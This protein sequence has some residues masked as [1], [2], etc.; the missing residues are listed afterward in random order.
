MNIQSQKPG[1]QRKHFYQMPLHQTSK[2]LSARLDKGLRK[3]LGKKT[4]PLRKGDDV[5]IMRGKNKKKKGKILRIDR[6]G[7]TVFIEGIIRKKSDGT[8]IP[9]GISSSNLLIIE[10]NRDDQKRVKGKKIAKEKPKTEKK[11]KVKK[12]G[13]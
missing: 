10:I 8:E 6:S 11:K 12:S 5:Q 13:K 9:V 4:L 3:E 2:I 7:M 1:K